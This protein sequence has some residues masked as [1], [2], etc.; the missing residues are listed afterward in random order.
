MSLRGERTRR[1]N[2]KV[3]GKWGSFM[4]NIIIIYFI[5]S[6]LLSHAQVSRN[7]NANHRH[8]DLEN[9]QNVNNTQIICK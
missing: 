9:T 2:N 7:Y 3:Q 5:I 4:D 8:I 6:G 1:F